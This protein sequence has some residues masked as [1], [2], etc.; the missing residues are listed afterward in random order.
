MSSDTSP[1]LGRRFFGGIRDLLLG[2]VPCPIAKNIH[3]RGRKYID[4]RVGV[5]PS[6][7][8]CVFLICRQ[9]LA[10]DVELR[11]CATRSLGESQHRH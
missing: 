4:L 7:R 3:E 8:R 1:L 10:S 5:G 11:R 9:E 2:N 6:K